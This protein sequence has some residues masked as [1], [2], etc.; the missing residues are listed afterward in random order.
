MAALI[1]M[2]LLASVAFAFNYFCFVNLAITSLRIRLLGELARAGGCLP[3]R[4]LLARYDTADVIAL[5][6]E[7]LVQGGHIVHRDGRYFSGRLHFLLVARIF[8]CLRRFILGPR[9]HASHGISPH[10]KAID[11]TFE[12]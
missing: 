8:D 5:R 9:H 10:P 11:G 4:A 3:E 12:Q 1:V 2:N 7:R 6:I